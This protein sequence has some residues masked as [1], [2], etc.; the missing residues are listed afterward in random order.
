[1]SG[2]VIHHFKRTKTNTI[3]DSWTASASPEKKQSKEL[4]TS[5]H[6]PNQNASNVQSLVLPP[7]KETGVRRIVLAQASYRDKRSIRYGEESFAVYGISKSD[8]ASLQQTLLT[9]MQEYRNSLK[10][11]KDCLIAGVSLTLL[12][13]VSAA[14]L[15]SSRHKFRKCVDELSADVVH[16]R[17]VASQISSLKNG[18]RILVGLN[19]DRFRSSFLEP[20]FFQTNL[21]YQQVVVVL[22][23]PTAEGL[24]LQLM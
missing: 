10:K 3:P 17:L 24:D 19:E 8:L 15:I 2:A 7:L 6:I 14:L 12:F 9:C 23:I 5:N 18:A 21:Y 1:M 4:S 11:A 22:E 20:G 16:L 13:P